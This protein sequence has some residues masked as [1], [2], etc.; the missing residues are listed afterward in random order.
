[1]TALQPLDVEMMRRALEIAAQAAE[2]GEIPVGAVVYRGD[3][4]LGEGGNR[5]EVDADPSGHAEIVAMRQ[6]GRA[7]GR[8]RLHDCSM[9][10]TLEPCAMCAGALVNARLQRVI[11]GAD[12]AKGGACTSLYQI[13]NDPRLNHRVDGVG[14]VLA[15]ESV[16]LL[17]AFFKTRRGQ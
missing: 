12:D 8:W 16:A 2:A 6:A 14:G 1:M 3:E 5:R 17:Q 13:H 10:V 9:A 15:E 11:W 4:V 7:L